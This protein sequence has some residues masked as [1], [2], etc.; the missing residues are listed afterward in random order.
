MFNYDYKGYTL[1]TFNKFLGDTGEVG[2]V[3]AYDHP[4]IRVRGLPNAKPKEVVLFENGGIGQI[5]TL[6]DMVLTI[7]SFSHKPPL[8][9]ERVVRT[10]QTMEV[11]VGKNLLGKVVDP[12]GNNLYTQMEKLVPE[13]YRDIDPNP[14]GIEKRVKI[15]QFFETGVAIVDMMVPLGKG[16]RELLI[17]NRKT[18][19]T[20][21]L[22]QTMLNQAKNGVICIYAGIGKTATDIK[23]IEEFFDTNKIRQNCIIVAS[24]ASDPPALVYLTPLTAMT[25]TDYFMENGHDAL[26]ILDDLTDHAKYY[27]ELALIAGK[28]PGRASYPAD[29]FHTHAKLLERAG[30]FKTAKGINA[31]TCLPVAETIQGDITGYI[32]TNLMSI[33][34]G[35]IF[36]DED[37]FIQ[38]IRP[39]VNYFLSVTRVGRQT[40]DKLKW[41]VGRELT[42]FL[43]L[44]EKTQSFV[45]FGAEINEGIKATLAMGEKLIY[46]LFNQRASKVMEVNLQIVLFALIWSQILN[47]KSTEQ[48]RIRC[49]Q[50]ADRY[51]T[52]AKYKKT[53][54]DI[55]ASCDSLN[56]L[57]GHISIKQS[58]LI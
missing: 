54:D 51:H 28:F 40:Q 38:G 25:I 2:Y 23:K 20:D 7:V 19:K 41:S 6:D 52:D 13:E 11:G 5:D 58:E 10:N 35:H 24:Y 1:D 16:Q 56:K 33:T 45:H 42:N 55:I 21:F 30:Y 37:L 27:R 31:I 46:G 3:D 4:I 17:G 50:I 47:A 44:L 12:L 18:G 26:L 15:N 36:F 32:Q 57:L 43:T 22:L 39:A 48:L 8:L 53:V 14:P 34:D 29:I 9:N 49:Q